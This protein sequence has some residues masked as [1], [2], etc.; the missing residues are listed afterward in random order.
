MK[1]S[2]MF[3][4]F[5]K[6]PNNPKNMFEKK[7]LPSISKGY[8]L[9]EE[10][11]KANAQ[12]N[13][14]ELA[15]QAYQAQKD[16]CENQKKIYDA[17]NVKLNELYTNYKNSTLKVTDRLKAVA[18]VGLKA[19]TG[20]RGN[21]AKAQYNARMAK[22]VQIA[23]KV[24]A[25]QDAAYKQAQDAAEKQKQLNQTKD[26]LGV[27]TSQVAAARDAT[28]ETHTAAADAA[29]QAANKVVTAVAQAKSNAGANMFGSTSFGGS[30]KKS[31]ASRRRRY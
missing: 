26:N 30:R 18:S 21:I 19:L 12:D 9:R 6:A 16:I 15:R 5:K 14:T 8:A 7:Y 1:G 22:T 13:N 25:L 28:L 4:M 2:G 27:V 10:V 17:C 11:K 31:R 24:D 29:A 3:N 20:T 23:D